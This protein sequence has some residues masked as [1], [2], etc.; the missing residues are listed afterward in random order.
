[1]KC[2]NPNNLKNPLTKNYAKIS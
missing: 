1:M 2:Y